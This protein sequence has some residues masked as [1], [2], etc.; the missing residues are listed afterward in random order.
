MYV[1]RKYLVQLNMLPLILIRQSVL[2][3]QQK[4]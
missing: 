3:Q 1:L 2:E 4:Q